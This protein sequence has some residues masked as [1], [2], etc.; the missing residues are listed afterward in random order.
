M[1]VY[2]TNNNGVFSDTI[3]TPNHSNL[4]SKQ[5]KLIQYYFVDIALLRLMYE[6]TLAIFLP[7]LL[8]QISTNSKR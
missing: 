4:K 5:S 1:C 3:T 7:L 2:A 6:Y 8:H